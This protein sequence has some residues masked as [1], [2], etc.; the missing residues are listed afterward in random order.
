MYSS[1]I[2]YTALIVLVALE[3]VGELVIARRNTQTARSRGAVEFGRSHYPLLVL[4]HAGLL[5]GSLAEVWIRQPAPD[6]GLSA[7]LFIFVVAA[8]TLRWWC[9]VSLGQQ[10]NT[11]VLV[12]PSARRVSHG[13]YRWLKHPNYVAVIVEGAALPL[14]GGAWITALVFGV[15]NLGVLAVRI[16]TE[17]RA[18]RHLGGDSGQE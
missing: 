14:V 8:Q 16:S 13:P 2:I 11:R 18:L 15:G 7:A 5:A 9:I 1:M 3:R 12:I 4:L 10:W 6:P 17:N